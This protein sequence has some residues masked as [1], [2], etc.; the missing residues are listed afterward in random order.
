MKEKKF[1]E[2]M[3]KLKSLLS[4]V[5]IDF[6]FPLIFILA[7]YLG[8]LPLFCCFAVFLIL[9]EMCHFLVAKKLG[10]LTKRIK[11]SFFGASLEGLDDFSPSDE[12][13]VISAGP[14]FNLAVCVLCYLSFWFNP[15][16][17]NYLYNIL[18]ANW[19]LLIFNILPVYPLDMGRIMLVI[20]TKNLIRERALRLTKIISFSFIFLLFSIYLISSF[21][22]LNITLGFVCVNLMSLLL[23]SAEGTSY[24]RE[25][26][27]FHKAKL[28][29]K[30]LSERNI[31]LYSSVPLYTLF[32]FID[33]YHFINFIFLSDDYEIVDTLSEI[34]LYKKTGFM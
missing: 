20:F 31:Y 30:G 24:K 13:K 11:I 2:I 21:F 12:L 29:S 28:I 32:K 14:A 19:A 33:D 17:Y 1:K 23:S 3:G 18:L 9:H 4:F 8:E 5:K 27:I 22:V 10:Y 26:F 7:Y 6:S 34:E 15:E 16:S 25:L